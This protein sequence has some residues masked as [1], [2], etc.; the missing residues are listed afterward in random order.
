MASRITRF[1]MTLREAE[2]Q[3]RQ[4]ERDRA[5]DDL[6]VLTISQAAEIIGIS[7]W[8]LQR[9]IKAG[10]GPIITRISDRRRGINI[11]NIRR[12]QQSRERA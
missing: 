10:K 2:K 8:T 7:V 5:V 4:D 6:R 12:W 9:L 1:A 3:R 11:G